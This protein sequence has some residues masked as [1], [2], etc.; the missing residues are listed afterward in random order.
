MEQKHFSYIPVLLIMCLS[1]NFC[2]AQGIPVGKWR[3]HLP[4]HH[5]LKVI[6]GNIKVFC[7]TTSGMFSYNKNDNSYEKMSKISGLSDFGITA[8]GYNNALDQLVVGYANGNVDI[9]QGNNIVNIADIKSKEMTGSKKINNVVVISNFAYLSCGFGI[10]VID[11]LK[12]EIKDTYLIGTNGDYLNINEITYDGSF[13]Y[14]A[15]DKG[16]Y[17]GRQDNPNLVNFAEWECITNIPVGQPY[18]WI[19]N[20]LFT[21]VA[22]FNNKV[23]AL[24]H[25]GVWGKDSILSYNGTQWTSFIGCQSNFQCIKTCNNLLLAVTSWD[26]TSYDVNEAKITNFWTDGF[27]PKWAELDESNTLW[28]AD[29]YGGLIKMD[30]A[31]T[32]ERI[33][34]PGPDKSN[35]AAISSAGNKVWTVAGTKDGSWNNTFT[36]AEIN[37]FIDEKWKSTNLSVQLSPDTIYDLFNVLVNPNNSDIVYAGAWN[38]GVVEF[39][40]GVFNKIYNLSNSSLQS[41]IPGSK[42]LRIYGLAVDKD[43][44]LWVANSGASSPFS[45]KTAAGNWYSFPYGSA[46]NEIG[47]LIVT[48]NN[49]KWAVLPRGS[50]LFAFNEKGTF[51]NTIDDDH[52]KFG[53]LD[54]NG[55]TITNDVFSIAED[56]KGTIWVGTNKGI[57]A[58]YNPENVFASSGF[59]AQQIKV[60]SEVAGQAN[61]LL[62]SDIVTAISVDGSNKKWIGTESA[63]VYLMTEDC[64]TQL[65][66]FTAENSPL[67]SNNIT[68]IA[69][70]GTSGE[71]F[72]G[73]DKGLISFRNSATDGAEN[74]NEVLVFPNPVKPEYTGLITIKGL[75]TNSNVKFTD[76]TGNIVFE[77]KAEGGMAVWNGKD[78]QG[79]R[80]QSG[81][82]LIFSTN[83]DGSK[84][85]VSKLLLVN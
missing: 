4:Y 80:V 70:N 20:K 30:N 3:D 50:G 16:I 83:E 7:I 63:G 48:Q 14:A 5:G 13:L 37:S 58:Y 65:Y 64:S 26:I 34:P 12:L 76:V 55:K 25:S 74:F 68:S 32:A 2:I 31:W 49:N 22:A 44:N 69:I 62:E 9:V 57:V 77:T 71:V 23:Y 73:T 60:P 45:V 38:Y 78:F 51:E 61:Y 85:N 47:S 11:L 42:I 82:Y 53:V 18:A 84:T 39:Q 81:V 21:N 8:A 59:Y 33:Y 41:M 1:L 15:T 27:N 43:N 24:Y 79:N 67:L 56:L 75:V 29:Y 52:K 6:V 66:H 54:E 35:V 36:D 19:T 72:F 17:K 46:A 40:N 28:V 10:V